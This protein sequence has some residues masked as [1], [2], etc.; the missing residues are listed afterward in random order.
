MTSNFSHTYH[1]VAWI[2]IRC[3]TIAVRRNAWRI[4]SI[5]S[6]IW[7]H[8][9]RSR[10]RG[11]T[12]SRTDVRIHRW[13]RW[14][15][16]RIRHWRRNEVLIRTVRTRIFRASH[17]H[18]RAA[19]RS[20]HGRTC[21]RRNEFSNPCHTKFLQSRRIEA[22]AIQFGGHLSNTVRISAPIEIGLLASTASTIHVSCQFW[23]LRNKRLMVSKS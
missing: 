8:G 9:W 21:G 11:W 7:H 22:H 1:V 19:A 13:L 23:A 4:S 10:G 5:V 18:P 20:C 3:S 14:L 12:S 2:K 16:P 15:Q 17:V 6:L